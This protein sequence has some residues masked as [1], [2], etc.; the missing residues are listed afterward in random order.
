M[1]SWGAL[2]K[3]LQ[4]PELPSGS[5]HGGGTNGSTT[6][7]TQEDV[8]ARMPME[9]EGESYVV[10]SLE[11]RDP[12]GAGR[13]EKS[14]LSNITD[15]DIQALTPN[16][17]GS[18]ASGKSSGQRTAHAAAGR[19]KSS[20]RNS[21]FKVANVVRAQ[22]KQQNKHR[23]KE[24]VGDKLQGLT[25]AMDAVHLQ[26]LDFLDDDVLPGEPP[27]EDVP[28]GDNKPFAG[29]ADAFQ[30]NTSMLFQRHA[31][32]RSGI[33]STR[34]G[35]A[36]TRTGMASSATQDV[37]AGAAPVQSVYLSDAPMDIAVNKGGGAEKR[38]RMLKHAVAAAN[39]VDNAKKTE[40]PTDT[41]AD[42]FQVDMGADDNQENGN[43]ATSDTS[44][45][46]GG[47]KG[48]G[49]SRKKV[50]KTTVF[51]EFQDLITPRNFST[52]YFFKVAIFFI[53]LPSAGIAAILFYFA[54]NPPTGVVDLDRSE[55]EGTL[56]NEDG[57]PVSGKTASASWW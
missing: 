15:T 37:E 54:D 3:R 32:T 56:L 41:A 51:Q 17:S 19:S 20:K 49:R 23:R 27:V 1:V 26:H 50:K 18:V 44:S 16:E 25:A 43:G 12:T 38:W 29:S 34:S 13:S 42:H 6:R 45:D 22:Q 9:T 46:E 40:T 48:N 36:S 11:N 31:S 35:M 7:L 30:Q 8:A 21:L 52:Y 4:Q 57:D 10:N 28:S 5:G 33:A 2:T 24:T 55:R 53:M 47:Q 39:M 14:I